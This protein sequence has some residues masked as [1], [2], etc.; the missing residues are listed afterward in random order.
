M[1]IIHVVVLVILATVLLS[2]LHIYTNINLL[3]Q[4]CTYICWFALLAFSMLCA[5]SCNKQM[6][7]IQFLI[8][9][10]LL[11]FFGYTYFFV[12]ECANQLL[13]FLN[14]FWLIIF[15]MELCFVVFIIYNGQNDKKRIQAKQNK[16]ESKAKL[17]KTLFHDKVLDNN[18]LKKR[19]ENW[20]WVNNIT[21]DAFLKTIY[22]VASENWSEYGFD[23][24]LIEYC[25]NLKNIIQ[26]IIV[27]EK[28]SNIFTNIEGDEKRLFIQI[29]SAMK[30]KSHNYI[31]INNL[32][33]LGSH[34]ANYQRII[35]SENER[36]NQS[37]TIS[38]IGIYLTILY[39][40]I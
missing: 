17:I 11:V 24:T 25:T 14:A 10:T 1:K 27:N 19:Y 36:N 35:K 26:P 5:M 31:D 34:I 38:I 28:E 4:A 20:G 32:I 8:G 33:E 9:F 18:E 39:F 22:D 29:Y 16:I 7:T 15:I 12:N 3:N 21:Y 40:L 13:P 37:L 2:V 23:E 30:E 6:S